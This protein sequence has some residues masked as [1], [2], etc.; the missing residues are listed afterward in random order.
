MLQSSATSDW[1]ES[2][3]AFWDSPFFGMMVQKDHQWI[4]YCGNDCSPELPVR[5]SSTPSDES[6]GEAFFALHRA[7]GKS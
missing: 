1:P 3:R 7:L 2:Y 5:L 6:A 4:I